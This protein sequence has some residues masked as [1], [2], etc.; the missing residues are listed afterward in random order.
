MNKFIVSERLRD[1]V[2]IIKMG[3]CQGLWYVGGKLGIGYFL[4][5]RL[6][7]V[8]PKNDRDSQMLP[9]KVPSVN[10]RVNT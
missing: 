4:M 7:S 9:Q 1:S 10:L 5:G 8:M 3:V 6:S 2:V